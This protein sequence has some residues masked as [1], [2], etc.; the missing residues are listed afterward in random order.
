MGV[1]C[2]TDGVAVVSQGGESD[3]QRAVVVCQA[4]GHP[5]PP[6]PLPTAVTLPCA[7]M[8]CMNRHPDQ[9]PFIPLPPGV[10]S[11]QQ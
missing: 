4:D 5:W 7:S 2:Q 8:L 11:P 3:R 10:T 6:Q 9:A 1:V